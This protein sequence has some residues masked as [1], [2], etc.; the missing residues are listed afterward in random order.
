MPPHASSTVWTHVLTPCVCP[1][2]VCC[3]SLP[4]VSSRT[5]LKADSAR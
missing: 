3:V 5:V 2:Y 4:A 1:V